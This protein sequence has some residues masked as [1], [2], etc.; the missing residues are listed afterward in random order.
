MT[1]IHHANASG[2]TGRAF[3]DAMRDEE[4]RE[5]LLSRRAVF[6]VAANGRVLFANPAGLS[7]LRAQGLGDV[8][9][10]PLVRM[11]PRLRAV[12]EAARGLPIGPRLRAE[13]FVLRRQPG[14]AGRLV[15]TAEHVEPGVARP[16]LTLAGA[17]ERMGLRSQPERGPEEADDRLR[18]RA[19]RAGFAETGGRFA[20]VTRQG[21]LIVDPRAAS[22]ANGEMPQSEARDGA[23]RGLSAG[24][25]ISWRFDADD[26]LQDGPPELLGRDLADFPPSFVA[27]ASGRCAVV[28][29]PADWPLADGRTAPARIFAR[30][31]VRPDGT[32]RGLRGRTVLLAEPPEI[33]D[34]EPPA[35]PVDAPS[36][37]ETVADTPSHGAATALAEPIVSDATSQA[38]DDGPGVLR[39]DDDGEA[40]PA[41]PER[42]EAH[43]NVGGRDDGRLDESRDE[44]EDESHDDADDVSEDPSDHGHDDLSASDQAVPSAI[45]EAVPLSTTERDA[46]DQIAS[47]LRMSEG[48]TLD[49]LFPL[50]GSDGEEGANDVHAAPR[51]DGG[52]PAEL[53]AVPLALVVYRDADILYLNRAAG[54]MLG[55]GS[56]EELTL[57]GGVETLFAGKGTVA[58]PD[59]KGV[60]TRRIRRSDGTTLD[61]VTGLRTIR[62]QAK[63]A[64][65]LTLR[66]PD[67]AAKAVENGGPAALPAGALLDVLPLG[68]LSLAGD[69]I[70]HSANT[71]AGELLG[72]PVDALLGQ[73]FTDLLC[74]PHRRAALDDLHALMRGELRPARAVYGLGTDL[75]DGSVPDLDLTLRRVERGDGFGLV[76]LLADA[77][78]RRADLRARQAAEAELARLMRERSAFLKRISH[79]LRTPLNAIVGFSEVMMEERFGPLGSTRYRDYAHDIQ[80]SGSRLIGMVGDLMDLVRL[81]ESEGEATGGEVALNEIVSACV[82]NVYGRAGERRVI[83]RCSLAQDLPLVRADRESLLQIVANLLDNSVRLTQA[84]GQ[85]IVSTNP[86][87]NGGVAV[88]VRD[89]SRLDAGLLRAT[90]SPF[91][92]ELETSPSG[93]TPSLGLPLTRA[94]A[95]ANGANFSIDSEAGRGTITQVLFPPERV[96][97]A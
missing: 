58:E 38:V 64:F 72:Q 12:L 92:I 66:R 94:L 32:Y 75:P 43:D 14:L 25:S 1:E 8:I 46:F 26:C 69:G 52:V 27:V 70:I 18:A 60:P 37:S 91:D 5:S 47:L 33:E 95:Q 39:D 80:E 93:T 54:R 56:A 6:A 85:V 35:P 34:S 65:L 45:A 87:D 44:N 2:P 57:D 76:A 41:H 86:L 84:G 48:G 63:T 16:R 21:L 89:G 68:V 78:Q 23:G 30:P 29:A 19:L 7:L 97:A 79:E 28:D 49:A 40:G 9:D 73:P 55:Y 50:A 10:R 61:L 59:A 82:A 96:F 83:I 31:V 90:V 74:E 17:V 36:E 22:A 11:A 81:Q 20:L 42:I 88:R 77:A 67:I 4:L 3:L 62:W 24:A 13:G 71:K 53:D 51:Q 15:L